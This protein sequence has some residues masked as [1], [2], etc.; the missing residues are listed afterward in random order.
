MNF[1]ERIKDIEVCLIED[2]NIKY[3]NKDLRRDIK[4]Y[5]QFNIFLGLNSTLLKPN[6]NLK[7]KRLHTALINKRK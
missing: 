7:H 2:L 5:N 6:K 4:V 3:L 1:K